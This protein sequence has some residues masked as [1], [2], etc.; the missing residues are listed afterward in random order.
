MSGLKS[1]TMHR[2][3]EGQNFVCSKWL[4]EGHSHEVMGQHA[5]LDAGDTR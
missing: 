3:Q 5:M 4:K 2:S 1:L